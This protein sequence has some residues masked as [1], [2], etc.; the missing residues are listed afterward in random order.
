MTDGKQS[1]NL[2]SEFRDVLSRLRQKIRTYVWVE[3]IAVAVTWVLLTFWLALAL[4]YL[5]VLFG[6]RELPWWP[7]AAILVAVGGVLGWILYRWILLRAFV[8]FRD[9]SLALLIERKFSEFDE[10]LITSIE[11]GEKP[12]LDPTVD[13]DMLEQTRLRAETNIA[14]IELNRVFNFRP[15]LVAAASALILFVSVVAFFFVNQDAFRIASQRLY[16]LA[17]TPWPRQHSIN[18]VGIRVKREN[19]VK[20]V[21]QIGKI[22]EFDSDVVRVARGSSI[23]LFVRAEIDSKDDPDRKVP[24]SCVL[25]YWNDSGQKGRQVLKKIGSPNNG[26]QLF[27]IDTAPFQNI[28]TGVHFEVRGGD[29]RVGP[30]EIVVVDEPAVEA[31]ELH[32]TFPN[33]MVDVESNRWTP[34]VLDRW[35]NGM[36]L[37]QGTKV[38]V[39]IR[40]NKPLQEIYAY[41]VNN[42]E[43]DM[44]R[45]SPR[46]G[47]G[48]EFVVPS[49]SNAVNME[50]ILHD[51]DGIVA[52]QPHR[53]VIGTIED[54]VPRVSASLYGIGSSIT[55]DA[56]IPLQG[57]IKDDY[58]IAKSWIE[59]R[60]PVTDPI[61]Q[62]FEL[63]SQRSL[64][65][66]VDFR[67]RQR[68]PDN[69]FRLP[70]E[71]GSQVQ[72]VVRSQDHCD[73]KN[74][75]NIGSGDVYDLDV[76][77]PDRLLRILEQ[78]EVGQRR[79][80]E[81]VFQELTDARGY[82]VRTQQQT[83]LGE[84]ASEPGD[85]IPSD[86]LDPGQSKKN[87]ELDQLKTHETQLLFAQR[88]V[89][90][91]QKS[92]Q[93]LAGITREFHGIRLQ[94][95]N[96]RVDSEDRKQQL[97][98]QVIQP[99]IKISGV[100]LSR[101]GFDQSVEPNQN[102][103]PRNSSMLI[104]EN[105]LVDLENQL[106]MVTTL[107]GQDQN[108]LIELKDEAQQLT[109]ES[110]AAIDGV[111]SEIDAILSVLVKY[112]TQNELLEIV[113]RMIE[114]EKSIYDRTRKERERQAF[115]DLLD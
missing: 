100:D 110:L 56:T 63:K 42:I 77:T 54:Q 84:G 61:E 49:L 16:L 85:S 55:P 97:Q 46:D 50:F 13:P 70:T 71:P 23:T 80:L 78:L 115:D 114:I 18:V 113:R 39:E 6:M 12:E 33:Y 1:S 68:D 10:S 29:H 19:P 45:I 60:T 94:L 104:L 66:A 31:M 44:V 72:L 2:S 30:M 7:R 112:E 58:D 47:N 34:R 81:Q 36:Q 93:E 4:D 64:D 95:V 105:K 88:A 73:L 96:N 62:F 21:D 86:V 108:Q 41:D 99:L 5:P 74:Q 57:N 89:L 83:S 67:D 76:V 65:V 109:R 79:R 82:V 43:A 98:S 9:S 3:G 111:L 51:E 106:R 38:K 103:E 25:K 52:E 53:L 11:A 32:C 75:P 48:F 28:L 92:S 69:G 27:S 59:L 90:Q 24:R 22:I 15:L 101:D 17:D 14:R 26:F 91:A 87:D 8:R 107:T 20:G 37:P 35:T 40:A 102:A